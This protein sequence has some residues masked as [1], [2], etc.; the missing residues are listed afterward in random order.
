MIDIIF[1]LF[2]NRCCHAAEEYGHGDDSSNSQFSYECAQPRSSEPRPSVLFQNAPGVFI[3]LP[4]KPS[5]SGPASSQQSKVGD[6]V[7]EPA[8]EQTQA[9]GPTRRESMSGS[10]FMSGLSEKYM[11]GVARKT[12]SPMPQLVEG[13]VANVD[14]FENSSK[15]S[16]KD[17]GSAKNSK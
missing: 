6:H 1:G 5:S 12:P 2:F 14:S 8:G 17:S 16:G 9:S 3:S 15:P 7:L 10:V 13:K 4:R 11:T